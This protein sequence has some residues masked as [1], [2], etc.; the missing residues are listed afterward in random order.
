MRTNLKRYRDD[1][2]GV[3]NK[4]KRM[5]ASLELRRLVESDGVAPPPDEKTYEAHLRVF[6]E[7]YQSWFTEAY[8]ALRQLLPSR[9]EE[10]DELYRGDKRRKT[11]DVATYS[12]K[13]WLTGLRAPED[14]TGK[15]QFKAPDVVFSKF[16]MQLEILA[17]VERRFESSLFE[18]RQLLQAD[19]F[20]SELEVAGELL[21]K[22][23]LRAAGIVAGVVLETHL[24]E[25]VA[26]HDLVLRKK[27]PGIADFNDMLKA[28]GVIE[29]PTWR[30]LQHL[31]D[32]RNICGH[33]KK[34]D[35]T[36]EE[37]EELIAGTTK[38]SKTVF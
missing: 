36:A 4:G 30:H 2:Q 12:V 38:V 6:G 14:W 20:D 16:K 18:I 32:I 7:S 28:K 15:K 37:V 22:G 23:H 11:F 10:F 19:L 29:V 21:K 5:L 34:R 25:V 3:L 27:N 31:G 35:P 24:A 8:A 13:D 33:K 9:L 26:A 1:L 17:S